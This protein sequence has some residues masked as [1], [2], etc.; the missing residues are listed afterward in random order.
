M[1]VVNTTYSGF[2][3]YSEIITCPHMWMQM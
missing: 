1:Q 2:V 3:D